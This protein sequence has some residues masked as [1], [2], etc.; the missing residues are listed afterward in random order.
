MKTQNTIISVL[1]L[2]LAAVSVTAAYFLSE[3]RSELQA[4]WE[5]MTSAINRSAGELDKNSGTAVAA[6]VTPEELTINAIDQ[7]DSRLNDYLDQSSGVT[8][9]RDHLAHILVGVGRGVS[10][11]VDDNA[12]RG[13]SSYVSAANQVK[14]GFNTMIERRDRN[15]NR[16]GK[17]ARDQFKVTLDKKALASGD[18][19]ALTPLLDAIK[20]L[21]ARNTSYS[22][23][24]S[25]IN[26]MADGPS[27]RVNT[28]ADAQKVYEQV[29]RLTRNFEILD[30]E[31]RNRTTQNAAMRARVAAN[32]K[33][34]GELDAV[35]KTKGM[36]ADKFKERLGIAVSDDPMPWKHG[37]SEAR[38]ALVG[39][40]VAVNNDY[41][42][43]G[44]DIGS[45]TTVVQRL[46]SG[47]IKVNPK[48]EPGMKLMIYRDDPENKA[49]EVVIS[50]V[51][52]KSS[53]A[54]VPSGS[55]P[56]KVGDLAVIID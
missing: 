40:V 8:K 21:N 34:A 24:L 25:R 55:Q 30:Q 4:G 16:L 45:D 22:G 35:I 44:L 31:L 13:I 26:S 7:L 10:V 20:A 47:L 43:V 15:F 29:A 33:L 52:A 17:F 28:P 27:L 48:I 6:K 46:G 9:N 18:R 51:G 12:L 1:I 50:E 53:T 39:K 36:E 37:S 38:K 19:A 32:D 23:N 56:I 42:Y 14:S 54:D 3:K 2:I 41:G 5:K 11:N 49:A